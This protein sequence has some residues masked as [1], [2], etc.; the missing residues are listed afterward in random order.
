[1]NVGEADIKLGDN[2]SIGPV[3]VEVGQTILGPIPIPKLPPLLPTVTP[4]TIDLS[5]VVSLLKL[6]ANNT[7]PWYT[8]LWRWLKRCGS[9]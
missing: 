6:I 9:H 5:E 8:K 2:P 7:T 4:V 3:H 1:M